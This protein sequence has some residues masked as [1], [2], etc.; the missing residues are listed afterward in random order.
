MKKYHAFEN[1]GAVTHRKH[2]AML[3]IYQEIKVIKCPQHGEK[4]VGRIRIHKTKHMEGGSWKNM[5][6]FK[7][8]I[9]RTLI[10]EYLLYIKAIVLRKRSCWGDSS[11]G[12]VPASQ[13]QRPEFCSQCLHKKMLDMAVRNG[14]PEDSTWVSMCTH[15]HAK[16]K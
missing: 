16:I 5:K 10:L 7:L 4:E 6:L 1:Y 15:T 11:V 9:P 13:T 2:P 3:A 12:K 14:I 8:P